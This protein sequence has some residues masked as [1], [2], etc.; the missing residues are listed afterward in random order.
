MKEWKRQKHSVAH[1]CQQINKC[2]NVSFYVS[3]EA[4]IVEFLSA[5]LAGHDPVSLALF[6][7]S[8]GFRILWLSLQVTKLVLLLIRS[9]AYWGK[10]Q[11]HQMKSNV[12]QLHN[13]SP[14]KKADKMEY[15]LAVFCVSIKIL[16]KQYLWMHHRNMLCT[17]T[18][19]IATLRM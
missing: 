17:T 3:P 9:L 13:K 4:V 19:I 6:G 18:L 10:W 16:S 2:G 14:S 8:C 12:L 15:Q 7:I 5:W 11:E 1:C